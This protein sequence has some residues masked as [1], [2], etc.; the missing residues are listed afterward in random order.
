MRVYRGREQSLRESD[1]AAHV[2]YFGDHGP[3]RPHEPRKRLDDGAGVGEVLDDAEGH[4][5]IE[6]TEHPGRRIRRVGT[7]DVSHRP[8]SPEALPRPLTPDVGVVDPA[9]LE[10]EC[11]E[12]GQPGGVRGIRLQR[13][14]CPAPGRRASAA[15]E[16]RSPTRA[17]CPRSGRWGRSGRST[18]SHHP[19]NGSNGP[20]RRCR[21]ASPT[22]D[23]T[24]QTYRPSGSA[25]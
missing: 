14:R 15:V 10:P 22:P 4:E 25:R 6:P 19:T 5:R 18:P 8:G 12:V 2:G 13:A 20:F 9:A 16:Q 11:G 23:L 24:V 7:H 21:R 1:H 17:R 3:A